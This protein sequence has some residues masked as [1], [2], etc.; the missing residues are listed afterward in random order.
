MSDLI[1]QAARRIGEKAAL[2]FLAS[3]KFRAM[4]SMHV[5]WALEGFAPGFGLKD[6]RVFTETV[7]QRIKEKARDPV[8][9]LGMTIWHKPPPDDFCAKTAEEIVSNFLRQESIEF[10]DPAY[11]WSE[12]SDLA[13]E[14]MHHWEACP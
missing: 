14:E 13:D 11:D 6:R 9:I 12:G 4:L 2:D 7:A 1:E 10:G 8:R 5:K 3:D